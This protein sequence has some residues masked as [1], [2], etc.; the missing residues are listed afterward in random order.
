MIKVRDGYGKLI[1]SDYN[2]NIAHVLLSNGGNLQYA[3]GSTASTLVQRNASGQIESSVAST[4]APFVISSTKVN[5]NLNA[6]LLDGFQ[7]TGLFQSLTSAAD[8]N[9]YIKIGDTEKEVSL[10]Y[11][12]YLGGVTKE[13][14]FTELTNVNDSTNPNSIKV[15]IGGTTKYLKVAYSDLAGKVVC[16]SSTNDVDRPIVVTNKSN[17]VYYST[18]VTLNYSTGNVTAPTFTGALIGNAD[19]ATTASKLSTVSKT[20]WGQTYWTSGGVPTSIS[21]DMTGVGNITITSGGNVDRFITFDTASTRSWRIGYLGSGSGDAN[22]L[23]FQSTKTLTAADGWHDMLKIGCETGNAILTGQLTAK[24]FVSGDGINDF[25]AGTVKLDVLNIPTSS[26][27]TT[28]GPGSN[29]QVLKSNG[30]TVYWASDNNSN[31]WRAVK[32]NGT[33]I[34]G[35]GTGT[36]ALT[37]NSGTGI[38]VTGTAGSSS[39]DNIVTITNAGVRSVVIGTGD[40]ANKVAVNTN[41]TTAYLTI[42]YATTASQLSNTSVS[43]PSKA[44][45]GQYLKWYSQVSQASG[46][47]GTN[48]GFPVSNNANGILW[49]GTHSGPYGWQMGFSSNGRIY[50][51]YISNNTFS[52]T[53]NGGSWSKIAWTSDIP[54]SLKNPYTLTFSAGTFTAKTYDGSAAVTVNIPTHT[55]HLTNNSGFLTSR[56]YIGTTAVQA[57][58]ASQSLTGIADITMS[59]SVNTVLKATSSQ[60][61]ALLNVSEITADT[62]YIHLYVSSLNGTAATTRALVLQN[63]YGNVGIGT[64]TPSAKLHVAGLVNITA[65]SG[66]LTIGCQNASWTHYS[67]TGGTHWFNKAVEVNGTL[68]PHA[69]NSFTLGTSSKRWSNVYSVLG[70]FSGNITVGGNQYVSESTY[71]INMQNS[72]IAQINSLYFADLA[73][74]ST[75]GIHFYR[76][77][78]TWD[79]LTA[80]NGILYFSGN[81][82]ISDTTLTPVFSALANSGNNISITIGG[83]NRTLTPAYATK[84]GDADTLDGY[85]RSNLYATSEAWFGAVGLTKSITV[86]GDSAYW[87]P[88]VI[89]CSA[90]KQRPTFISV[91]KNL[92]STTPS[93]SGNHSNGTSSLWL[94]YEMR[95]PYWDG[96]GGYIKT[97]YKYQGYATLVAHARTNTNASGQLIVWLRGGTCQYN[98]S[99]TNS[100]SVN[101]Y[102]SSTNISGSSTYPDNVDKMSSVSNGGIYTSTYLGYGDISGNAATATT[103]SNVVVNNSDANST[104]RMVWHSGNTLYGTGGIYCNPSTDCLYASHYYETSDIRKKN[105]LDYIENIDLENIPIVQF[106]WKEKPNKIHIGSIAQEVE[107][108]LP[109]VVEIGEDGYKSIDYGVLGTVSGV[110]AIKQLTKLQEKIKELEKEIE[111]LKNKN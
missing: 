5:A 29:G 66:T 74:S 51:R 21:G 76:S 53:A 79:T 107:K 70:N 86:T 33:Q 23:A 108:I 24:N 2:G 19:T 54:T 4:V 90:D 45:S 67:T 41:G 42:P 46:Y 96:N 87:Y 81:R 109:E 56:G 106:E 77:T 47:A 50:A 85:H 38:T 84:A 27:G 49:L 58:S 65:N 14:L 18:K 61:A 69:N 9:L 60:S 8:K 34:A 32:V 62:N 30:T 52:T 48:Y 75:E 102:Y 15:T 78:T 92:G 6:D 44:A 1:G 95:N 57:S 17:G 22:Y 16:N 39:T 63:G 3:V 94:Q 40:N 71:G 80:K 91:W 12:S 110:M 13:G 55:S 88:V 20:A 104:Y 73:D 10:L 36:Y 37:F 99:C 68:T 72:D 105:I 11:A 97:W 103:A 26:G 83:Q 28:F 111:I 35:T 101:V 7:A 31:S 64:P 25:S 93:I 98:I 100:F 43:D 89:T 82:A 59:G